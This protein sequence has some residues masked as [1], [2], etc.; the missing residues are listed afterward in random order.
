MAGRE[1]GARPDSGESVTMA[2]LLG[3]GMAV[4]FAAAVRDRLSRVL[5]ALGLI[6]LC[7]GAILAILI[8]SQIHAFG[9][10]ILRPS[11]APVTPAPSA[12]VAPAPASG[13]QPVVDT[14]AITR[15]VIP[16]INV[17]APVAVKGLGLQGVMEAPD[18]PAHVVWYDFSARPGAGGNAV[19]AG[20][21]DFAS[22]GPAV[23]WNLQNLK[24]QDVIEVHLADGASYRYRVT[25]MD[26]FDDATA[27]LDRIVGSTP[28]A[29]V[30]LITCAGNFNRAT[31]R[32]D[33]RL[34]VRG[35]LVPDGPP[36]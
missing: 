34:V 6:S 17:D 13:T 22:V 23:F 19:F 29:S 24:P 35:E 27:P 12:P 28:K 31:Q 18:D 32:Y 3:L 5:L 14:A 25:A 21:V 36:G 10:D 26:T 4:L 30:T 7:T 20:H 2:L 9:G 16:A 33:Q 11:S 8:P 15:L 1:R